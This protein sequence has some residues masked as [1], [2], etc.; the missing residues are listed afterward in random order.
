MESA[1]VDS[2]GGGNSGLDVLAAVS[3]MLELQSELSLEPLSL[4]RNSQQRPDLFSSGGSDFA[5]VPPNFNSRFL[6]Q[7]QQ[8]QHQQQFAA[9]YGASASTGFD[10]LSSSAPAAVGNSTTY[11]PTISSRLPSLLSARSSLSVSLSPE[12]PAQ[13]MHYLNSRAVSHDFAAPSVTRRLSLSEKRKSYEQQQPYAKP[14]KALNCKY[15]YSKKIKCSRTRPSCEGCVKRGLSCEYY[16]ADSSMPVKQSP[17]KFFAERKSSIAAGSEYHYGAEI[18]SLV[19][20]PPQFQNIQVA[21]PIARMDV[22]TRKIARLA[23]ETAHALATTGKTLARLVVDRLYITSPVPSKTRLTCGKLWIIDPK[24]LDRVY[25]CPAC[26][27]TYS[28]ANGLKYHLGQHDAF[29]NGL[30]YKSDE[31]EDEEMG[32]C[33]DEE[34]RKAFECTHNDGCRNSYGSLGGLKYHLEHAHHQ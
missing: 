16:S 24:T 10:Y 9:F 14:I 29:P 11:S 31:A 7:R 22:K 19:T 18:N 5:E 12:I 32:E 27:K 3:A 28:T 2:A 6:E 17:S 25:I 13:Q 30:Y 33:G 20:V 1:N 15:C 21:L 4:R 23:A 34:A 8:H 26:E